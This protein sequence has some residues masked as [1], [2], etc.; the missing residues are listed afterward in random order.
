MTRK[1]I[2]YQCENYKGQGLFVGDLC[3]P[4][5]HMLTTGQIN[6]PSMDF[7]SRLYKSAPK[8]VAKI[9]QD[10]CAESPREMDNLGT[11]CLFHNRYNVPDESGLGMEWVQRFIHNDFNGVWLPVYAYDHSGIAL[12]TTPFSCPWDS[13]QLGVIYVTAEKIAAE[14]P[15][16]QGLRSNVEEI[17]RGE[18]KTYGQYLNGECYG[19]VLSYETKRLPFTE[20]SCWGFYGRDDVEAAARE[21]GAVEFIN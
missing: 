17:L 19:Y 13:G 4:C 16:M 12:S 18:V 14:C 3:G 2:V 11:L 15:D 20:D 5:H 9:V 6:E 8:L 21:A 10:E 1:C 7:V